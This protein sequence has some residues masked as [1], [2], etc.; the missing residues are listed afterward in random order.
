VRGRLRRRG[1]RPRHHLTS[2]QV[3]ERERGILAEFPTIAELL[4]LAVAAGESPV[5]ALDRVVRRSG[6]ELS[7]TWAGCWPRSAPASPSVP[8]STA[9]PP[10]PACRWSRGSPRASR[11]PSSAARRWPTSCTPRPPTSAR[12]GRRE[13][14]EVAARKEVF[15]MVPVVFLVLPVTVLFA[16]WPG[17]IGLI[18]LHVRNTLTAAASDGARLAATVDAGPAD[19]VRR[20]REQIAGA[21]SARFARDVSAR[22]T[23][24]AGQQ[25]VE[26]RVEAVVPPLGLWGPATRL[27]LT[28]HAIEEPR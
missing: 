24:V 23:V 16:F 12:P 6:G 28:G 14:I 2:G 13:L 15:M 1:P 17:V 18:V 27:V 20:A 26:V 5:A 3:K 8:P 9:G 7:P 4:A 21:L 19:G 25:G 10:P 11:S 22:P